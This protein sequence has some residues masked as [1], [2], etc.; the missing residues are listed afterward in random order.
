N[1]GELDHVIPGDQG[2]IMRR[3]LDQDKPGLRVIPIANGRVFRVGKNRSLWYLWGIKD[4]TQ[5]ILRDNYIV[6]T[7]NMSLKGRRK[8]ENERWRVIDEKDQLPASLNS[9][10]QGDKDL[11][12]LRKEDYVVVKRMHKL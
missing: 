1:V 12:S 6:T 11:L 3:V 10:K 4:P 9:K 2:V 7:M 8:I 5:L